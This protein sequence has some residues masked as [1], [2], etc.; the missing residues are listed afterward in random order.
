VAHQAPTA[1]QALGD[2]PEGIPDLSD[3]TPLYLADPDSGNYEFRF[4]L[5]NLDISTKDLFFTAEKLGDTG[6][7]AQSPH[8]GPGQ[9]PAHHLPAGQHQLL[10]DIVTELVGLENEVDARNTGFQLGP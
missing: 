6:R 5:G 3:K 7:G 1:L 9:V 10:H 8:H 4:F 2:P